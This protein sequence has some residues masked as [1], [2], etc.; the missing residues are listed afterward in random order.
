MTTSSADTQSPRA[1]RCEPPRPGPW[2]R[3]PPRPGPRPR[4]PRPRPG[5]RP[6]DNT[7]P[8]RPPPRTPDNA[9]RPRPAPRL[10]IDVTVTA[11]V[12]FP[13]RK[14]RGARPHTVEDS[15]RTVGANLTTLQTSPAS[16]PPSSSPRCHRPA[17]P[18]GPCAPTRLPTTPPKPSVCSAPRRSTPRTTNR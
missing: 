14:P 16:P 3:P 9:S 7:P 11:T 1:R 13:H 17:V 5:P 18:C 10:R 2:P 8:P 15:G 12:A 6:P 4:P